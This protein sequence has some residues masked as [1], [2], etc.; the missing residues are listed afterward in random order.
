M[1]GGSVTVDTVQVLKYYDNTKRASAGVSYFREKF[2]KQSAFNYINN[3]LWNNNICVTQVELNDREK[4]FYDVNALRSPA[5][6][7]LFQHFLPK[8]SIHAIAEMMRREYG[9]LLREATVQTELKLL[10]FDTMV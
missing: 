6:D 7:E 8:I 2:F 1:F 9:F 10:R 5:R 3:L 4:A